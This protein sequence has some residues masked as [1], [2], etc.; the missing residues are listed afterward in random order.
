[1][2]FEQR[3]LPC[4]GVE[5]RALLLRG[6]RGRFPHHAKL[7][8][9]LHRGDHIVHLLERDGGIDLLRYDYFDQGASVTTGNG[10]HSY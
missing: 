8:T 10:G 4:D 9:S 2:G 1:M 7:V 5:D 6:N 3:R